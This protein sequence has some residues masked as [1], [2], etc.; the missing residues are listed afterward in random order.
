MR[1][2]LI[3]FDQDRDCLYD[4]QQRKPAGWCPVCGMEIYADGENLC[5]RCKEEESENTE[6]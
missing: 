6:G 2:F 4:P 3:G 1:D 5:L